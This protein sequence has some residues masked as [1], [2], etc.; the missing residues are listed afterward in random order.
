MA[1]FK[2]SGLPVANDALPASTQQSEDRGGVGGQNQCMGRALK[3]ERPRGAIW[4]RSVC[5]GAIC[6][7]MHSRSSPV[8]ALG[9][10]LLMGGK[11]AGSVMPSAQQ[12]C[13]GLIDRPGQLFHRLTPGE[14]VPCPY[15]AGGQPG[16]DDEECGAGDLPTG[17]T[18]QWTSG[19]PI[20]LR[21]FAS[22][23]LRNSATPRAPANSSATS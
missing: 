23:S 9:A 17:A 22:K 15:R 8:E 20:L 1:T 14:W 13:S 12:T 11:S 5:S 2:G 19:W 4:P 3:S 18:L 10:G 7:P 16:W 6:H 21:Y